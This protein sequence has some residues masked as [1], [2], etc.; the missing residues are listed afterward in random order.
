MGV[1][2][3]SR[4]LG[5]DQGMTKEIPDVSPQDAWQRLVENVEAQLI[6][7]RTEA[8]WVFVGVPDLGSLNKRTV[9]AQWSSFPAQTV[10]PSFVEQLGAALDVA[11]LGQETELF[12]LCRSGVRSLAAARV[13]SEAGFVRCH[14]VTDGFE[15]PKDDALHRGRIGGWKASGLPW[16]QS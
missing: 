4:G 2:K 10:D 3:V 9:H 5:S 7:V 1:G 13:M 15:G 14:N 8:E 11:G 12:F 16:S 6:D